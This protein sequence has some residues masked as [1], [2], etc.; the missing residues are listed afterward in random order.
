[1]VDVQWCITCVVWIP[2]LP[3]SNSSPLSKKWKQIL[4]SLSLFTLFPTIFCK[5]ILSVYSYFSFFSSYA[6]IS[7]TIVC[8]ICLIYRFSFFIILSLFVVLIDVPA[9]S[10]T[11]S[12]I[13]FNH[14][15]LNIFMIY[16]LVLYF[17]KKYL[18]FICQH[19]YFLILNKIIFN[20]KIVL[21]Y[22]TAPV[23]KRF[24]FWSW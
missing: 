22:M 13:F 21:T 5:R 16:Q 11:S 10:S 9:S 15:N 6:M 24:C 23:A 12:M 18:I 3:G 8:I 19:F 2:R 7:H 14:F 4:S 1:M 17:G 20:F